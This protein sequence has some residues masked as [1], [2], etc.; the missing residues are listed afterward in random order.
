MTA[1]VGAVVGIYVDLA[2]RIG[3]GDIIETQT[4]RRYKVLVVREQERGRHVGR[5]H[6]RCL[7]VD[8]DIEPESPVFAGREGT[9]RP[10]MVHRI[11]WYSRTARKRR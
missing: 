6:L 11:R 4:G 10:G 8:D 2:E 5:Q 1:P 9:Q 7:V 3:S